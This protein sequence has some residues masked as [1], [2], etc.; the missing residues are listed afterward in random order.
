MT[1][2][3]LRYVGLVRNITSK[4]NFRSDYDDLFQAGMVGLQ[5][6]LNKSS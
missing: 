4:Y 2:E 5:T 6:A 3:A 1:E